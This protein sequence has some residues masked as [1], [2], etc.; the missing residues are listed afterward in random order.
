MAGG[1]S[2]GVVLT[3]ERLRAL[4]DY[5]P[6]TGV[7]TRRISRKKAR[8]GTVAARPHSGTR[9]LIVSLDYKVHLAHRL[10]WLHVYGEWPDGD[11]DHVDTD[12]TNNAIGN[13]RLA[14]KSQNNANRRLSAKSASGFKGVTWHAKKRKWQ[15]QIKLPGRN[16]YLGIYGTPEA[17]HAAY[18]QAA[19]EYFGE[20]ARAA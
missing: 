12:P 14:T 7:F 10:A 9:Y 8:K 6:E 1:N 18:I 2:R 4:I 20:F 19:N 17:A 13:L 15:A 11:I 16:L 5:D 3:A